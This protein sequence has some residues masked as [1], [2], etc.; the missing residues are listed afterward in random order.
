MDLS[1]FD[2]V[3]LV[4]IGFFALR[5]GIRGMVK[6]LLSMA[7]VILGFAGAVLFSGMLAGYLEP[8]FGI[9]QPWSQIASFLGLFVIVYVVVK[10]FEGA[11]NNIIEKIRMKSLDHALGFLLGIVEGL[12]VVLILLTL[13]QWQNFF[14]VDTMFQE[15]LLAHF[16]LPLLPYAKQ[17]FAVRA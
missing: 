1:G 3:G 4:L 2:I 16:L 9:Q 11:L 14:E 8:Q 15:S 12:I 10:L 7:A 17:L 13:L 5:T 6:E